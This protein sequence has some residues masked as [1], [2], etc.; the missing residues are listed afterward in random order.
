MVTVQQEGQYYQVK[1]KHDPHVAR[2]LRGLPRYRYNIFFN[3]W[4][5]P[6][7]DYALLRQAIGESWVENNSADSLVTEY[8]PKTPMFP[9]QQVGM[10]ILLKVPK[11]IVADEPGTG[12]TKMLID[13]MAALREQE[14]IQRVL[15]VVKPSLKYNW[16]EEIQTHSD[17]TAWVYEGPK[18]ARQAALHKYAEHGT[19]LFCIV[20]YDT[21]RLDIA[22][23]S[24]VR[25]DAVILDEAHK[26]KNPMASTTKA[27]WRLQAPR[28]YALTGT[29]IINRPEEAYSL[30]HWL[31]VE[32][33]SYGAFLQE[34]FVGEG[35]KWRPIPK[36]MQELQQ[37]LQRIML[38]RRK[39]DVLTLPPKVRQTI[40]VQLNAQQRAVYQK[41][42]DR[43]LLEMEDET[44]SVVHLLAKLT[45]LK[46]VTDSVELVGVEETQDSAKIRALRELVESLVESGE[47][48]IIFTQYKRF[49]ARLLKEFAKYNPAYI[50]GDVSST[51]RKR[52]GKSDRQAM[53]KKFQKDPTC[54]IFLGVASACREGLTLTAASY[55][56]FV[57]KE[58]A[59]SY[60]EQA[61]DRAHRIGTK[62]SLTVYTLAAKGTIEEGIERL[63]R[64]KKDVVEALVDGK[65]TNW[66]S[67]L[68]SLLDYA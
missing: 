64:D 36:K 46:E 51:K 53:V 12:K 10:D 62:E 41:L 20:S 11:F 63:L 57:D 34:Y 15:V 22:H 40:W 26:I 13:T 61:E 37:R 2:K 30:L 19:A 56:I 1:V 49:H 67:T 16:V 9:H 68:R 32:P 29:P 25:W 44:V 31:G 33:R 38:R 7:E 14:G 23:L 3:V 45:Y 48:V 28:Q 54:R 59:P 43:A 66:R 39:A 17:H 55:V 18:Q 8:T 52:D 50:T 35:Y 4:R 27:I 24:N 5:V 21:A 65:S 47:K 58:W 60:V 42:R 6:V